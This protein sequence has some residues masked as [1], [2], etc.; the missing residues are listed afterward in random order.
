MKIWGLN[1]WGRCAAGLMA[2]AILVGTA[3]A[4]DT[5]GAATGGAAF[6][7]SAD[8]TL[9]LD[10]RA[11]LAW[12][13]CVEGMQ[14]DGTTCKGQPLRMTSAEAA[15]LATERWKTT[16]V[17][18]RLPRVKELQ[19]LVNKAAQPPG[20]DPVLFPAAPREWHWSSSANVNRVTTN[21]YNYGNIS[22]GRTA[23]QGTQLGYLHGWAVNLVS[24]ETDGEVAKSSRL[25]VRLVRPQPEPEQ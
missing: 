20:L 12:A 14:W 21:Q 18:W 22:S 1:S 11:K 2:G 6:S 5:A 19:R 9:V 8:G 13:R 7:V 3:W 17:R 25:P 16:Q 15:T 24:G 10:H 23:D 4:Q